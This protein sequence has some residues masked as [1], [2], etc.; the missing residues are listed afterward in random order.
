[1]K[2]RALF[3]FYS[4][5]SCFRRVLQAE[6]LGLKRKKFI[7]IQVSN[8]CLKLYP[9]NKEIVNPMVPR[10]SAKSAFNLYNRGEG[11]I[12]FCWQLIG[13]IDSWCNPYSKGVK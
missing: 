12:F 9:R 3:L 13:N 2:N 6:L 8:C 10:I 7:S 1:M 5:F 11:N 4:S